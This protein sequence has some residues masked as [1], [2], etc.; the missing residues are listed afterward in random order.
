MPV[1]VARPVA[2]AGTL[3]RAGGS[4]QAACKSDRNTAA[5]KSLEL[6]RA[7]ETVKAITADIEK[8]IIPNRP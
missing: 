1:C 5:N 2:G 3:T 8:R 4:A 6:D 7:G